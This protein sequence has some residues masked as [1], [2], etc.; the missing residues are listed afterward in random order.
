M[1]QHTDWAPGL[2]MLGAGAVAAVAF[3]VLAL[4][5]GGA[6]TAR[7]EDDLEAR[8]A[9]LLQQLKDHAAGRARMPEAAWAAEQ[10]RL[11][12]AAALVL[13]AKA[14][15][16]HAAAKAATRAE[17]ATAEAAEAAP[18]SPWAS[19][20]IAALVLGFF[21]LVGY[22]LSGAVK[23]KDEGMGPMGGMAGG[24][25]AQAQPPQDPALMAL[26][27]AAQASPNDADVVGALAVYLL[28]EQAFDDA[29]PVVVQATLA[30]PYNVKARIGRAVLRAVDGEAAPAMAELERL[31]ATYPE[32]Y[33]AHLFAGL[34]AMDTDK[35]RALAQFDRYLAVSPVADQPP[36]LPGAMAKLRAELQAAPPQ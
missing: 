2:W 3:L 7:A 31:G 33:D 14:E 24:A 8:Y 25:Q 18:S 4:R 17:K 35:P 22:Q 34:I 12:E 23:P 20:A 16:K 21:G 5:K 27:Q 28:R 10:R 15:G 13:R 9:S 36:A 19:V 30:D 11:E 6:P 26:V 1:E 32:A 29:R